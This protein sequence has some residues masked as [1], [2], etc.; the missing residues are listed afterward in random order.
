MDECVT[1][2]DSC[3][4]KPNDHLVAVLGMEQTGCTFSVRRNPDSVRFTSMITTGGV[5]TTK[6]VNTHLYL[7][8]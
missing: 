4:K 6:S 3:K 7:R 1:W 5:N 2:I 8:R